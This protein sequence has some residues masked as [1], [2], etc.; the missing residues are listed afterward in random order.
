VTNEPAGA[1][2]VPFFDTHIHFW[3][4]RNPELSYEF[5][6]PDYVSTAA[7]N[8]DLIKSPTY[9]FDGYRAESRFAKVVKAVH[10]QAAIG[11]ADPVQ[12]TAWLQQEADRISL[13]LAIVAGAPLLAA[14]LEAILERHLAYA[15]VRGIR[16]RLDGTDL[17]DRAF[18]SG[19]RLLAKY[20]LS[21]EVGCTWQHM[22]ELGRV[23]G[24]HPATRFVLVHMGLPVG[25]D[26]EYFAHWSQQLRALARFDNISCKIS[27]VG[28]WDPLW[29]IESI[30]PWVMECISAFGTSR[31]F[32]ASNWPIDRQYSSFDSLITAMRECISVFT[33]EEQE[34]LFLHNAERAYRM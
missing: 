25:R 10:I 34:A 18:D 31:C 27:G 15:N 33:R 17:G 23:A 28:L 5:L 16:D 30:R 26:A 14:D 21:L 19:L 29:T 12:E 24:R 2:G 6:K 3:H 4:R 11:T 13:P 1:V 8:V 22:P 7:G 20:D 32:F 9:D